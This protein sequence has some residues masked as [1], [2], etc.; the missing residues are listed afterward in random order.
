MAL[1]AAGQ[2]GYSMLWLACLCPLE[3]LEGVQQILL[4][5]QLGITEA[6]VVLRT[7]LTHTQEAV[8]VM[9]QC[10]RSAAPTPW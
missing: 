1:A 7:A 10:T 3:A 8:E 6:E 4:V 2:L 5:A 9:P